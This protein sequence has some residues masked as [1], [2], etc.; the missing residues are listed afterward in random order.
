MDLLFTD[1]SPA[2]GFASLLGMT[3]A[4]ISAMIPNKFRKN[5]M[6]DLIK[7]VDGKVGKLAVSGRFHGNS[8]YIEDAYDITKTV[9]GSG[10]SGDVRLAYGRGAKENLKFA[11]KTFNVSALSDEARGDLESEIEILFTVDHPNIAR[12]VDVYEHGDYV[13]LVTECLDGGELFTRLRTAKQFPEQEAAQAVQQML[14]AA[15]YLHSLG[16]VHRDLKLENFMYDAKDSSRLVLIDFGLSKFWDPTTRMRSACGTTS[17]MAPEVIHHSYTSQCDMWSLG[18]I[19]FSLLSGKMPFPGPKEQQLG[20]IV[21]GRYTM[22][23][24]EWDHISDDAK[25]FVES[26]LKVDAFQRLTASQAMQHRWLS[27]G[28]CASSRRDVEANAN[29]ARALLDFSSSSRF[30]RACLTV[31]AWSLTQEERS[32]VS[33]YFLDIDMAKDGTLTLDEL[34]TVMLGKLDISGVDVQEVFQ[35]LDTRKSGRIH[36]TDF[37]AAMISINIP[38]H[39][40]LL[41]AAFDRFDNEY[42]GYISASNLRQVLGDKFDGIAVKHL[43]S[44]LAPKNRG[45]VT[46]SEFSAFLTREKC[47]DD[48]SKR[49]NYTSNCSTWMG[50]SGLRPSGIPSGIARGAEYVHRCW[51]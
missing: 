35:M 25:N 22:S 37:L 32:K 51:A 46:F 48:A 2:D 21:E 19:A 11:V 30:R 15:G 41:Q 26:L 10:L 47:V 9:L 13:F 4:S 5:R 16:I 34:E 31:M 27:Q 43:L 33:H 14:L 7:R 49:T 3:V 36:Y 44:E 12:L 28:S 18:V 29:V 17:Y 24:C 1:D 38:M 40:G 23:P 20:A 6:D 39:E 8:E 42:S 45:K 50:K